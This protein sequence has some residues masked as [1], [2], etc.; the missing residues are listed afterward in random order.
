VVDART[1][2][3]TGGTALVPILRDR[4]GWSCIGTESFV[5]GAFLIFA[6]FL[7][8]GIAIVLALVY[9]QQLPWYDR[10]RVNEHGGEGPWRETR[11]HTPVDP[12]V[13]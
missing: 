3:T 1:W 5:S 4:H 13:S 8:A 12:R 9:R 11:P 10:A 2:T 7:A 6:S